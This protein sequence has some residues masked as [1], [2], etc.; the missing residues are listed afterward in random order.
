MAFFS[1]SPFYKHLLMPS[2][3]SI[4]VMAVM[5][6]VAVALPVA[7]RNEGSGV[8]DNG[9]IRSGVIMSMAVLSSVPV[10]IPVVPVI[11]SFIRLIA[12]AFDSKLIS[13]AIACAYLDRAGACP[14][15][16]AGSVVITGE[17]RGRSHC[18]QKN[19]R[20]DGLSCFRHSLYPHLFAVCGACDCAPMSRLTR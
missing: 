10:V 13:A 15:R 14:L 20:Q 16:K 2:P 6:P 7:G 19:T 8:N 12:E 5:M 18:R 3:C 17:G 1:P 11:I 9:L 4:S